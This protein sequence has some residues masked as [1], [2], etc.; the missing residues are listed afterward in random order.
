MLCTHL[1]LQSLNLSGLQ[2]VDESLWLALAHT[3]DPETLTHQPAAPGSAPPSRSTHSSEDSACSLPRTEPLFAAVDS[4]A[5]M[6][7]GCSGGI[8]NVPCGVGLGALHAVAGGLS[9]TRLP[10]HTLLLQQLEVLS[11]VKCTQLPSLCLGL[12]PDS[13]LQVRLWG[14]TVSSALWLLQSLPLIHDVHGLG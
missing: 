13:P 8:S 9:S 10:S 2:G 12:L 14:P 5:T 3:G 6:I 4:N 11:L 1:A 7:G